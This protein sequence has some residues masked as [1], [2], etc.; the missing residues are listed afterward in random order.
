[1]QFRYPS[2]HPGFHGSTLTQ[3]KK[4]LCGP[5]RWATRG[6]S[7]VGR[8]LGSGSDLSHNGVTED[9]MWRP[10]PEARIV[11]SS[12]SAARLYSSENYRATT[13]EIRSSLDPSSADAKSG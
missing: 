11:R 7:G 9:L 3:T 12:G 2:R 1:M 8:V 5:R 13:G 6:S 10:H 4:D